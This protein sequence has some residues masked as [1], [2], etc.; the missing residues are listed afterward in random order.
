MHKLL[1]IAPLVAACLLPSATHAQGPRQATVYVS[2][3]DDKG[4]P[5][6]GL[7]GADFRV[8]EDNVPRE[9]LTAV[10]ATE[11][12]SVALLIDDSQATADAIQ[13]IRDGARDFIKA[14]DG[15]A[16]ISVIT[17]GERPTIA[18]D[19]TTDQKRLLDTVGRIFQRTGS[20]AYFQDAI[21]EISKGF[22][23]RKPA[24]P[25]I[26]ALMFEDDQEFSNRFYQQVLEELDRGGA[27]LHVIAV[28][29]PSGDQSDELRNRNQVLSEGT[30]RTGG[31][32]DQVLARTAIPLRMKQ[33]GDELANQ[34]QVTY[35]R[36][37]RLIPAD[38]LEVTVTKPGATARAR[39][40]APVQ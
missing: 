40:K 18:L 30:D 13:M 6:T 17:F 16:E 11:R 20:G 21:V 1:T 33:L 10:P 28:G 3:L 14:L 29:S 9:V 32:R 5:V 2:V 35:G 7:T 23:K 24:R 27:A 8:R 26:A 37:E 31:R 34:Y 12:L 22:Q 4:N 39:T 36:P 38:K 25:V 15:K 19:Y